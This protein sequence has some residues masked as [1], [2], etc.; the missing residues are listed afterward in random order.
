MV[1]WVDLEI[2]TGGFINFL[3]ES[4]GENKIRLETNKPK[5]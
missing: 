2:R 1:K 5:K 3:A 4:W